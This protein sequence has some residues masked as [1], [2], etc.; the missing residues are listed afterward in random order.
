MR[1]KPRSTVA[2]ILYTAVAVGSNAGGDSACGRDWC[3]VGA[4]HASAVDF[5][6]SR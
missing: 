6:F 1:P 4:S 3:S 2:Q 5:T